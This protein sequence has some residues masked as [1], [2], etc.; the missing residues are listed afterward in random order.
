[1]T[2]TPSCLYRMHKHASEAID[3]VADGVMVFH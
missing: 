1:M 3:I 2:G